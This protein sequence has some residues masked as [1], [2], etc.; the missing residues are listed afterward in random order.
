MEKIE[1]MSREEAEDTAVKRIDEVGKM[2]NTDKLTS[3]MYS[4]SGYLVEGVL[5]ECRDWQD[6]DTVLNIAVLTVL[7]HF[8][9]A[10][11][12]DQEKIQEEYVKLLQEGIM[13]YMEPF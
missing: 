2:C 13:E 7:R 6:R 8:C 1:L 10:G 5:E 3:T 12:L 4:Y 9:K 11:C